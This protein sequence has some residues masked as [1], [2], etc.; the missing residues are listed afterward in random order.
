MIQNLRR[1]H[2]KPT[3]NGTKKNEVFCGCRPAVDVFLYRIP[4]NMHT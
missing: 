2:N 3:F 1:R 4:K